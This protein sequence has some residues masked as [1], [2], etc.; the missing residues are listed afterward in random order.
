MWIIG[1]YAT[2]CVC[3]L[4][5]YTVLCLIGDWGSIKHLYICRNIHLVHVLSF[6]HKDRGWKSSGEVHKLY[7]QPHLTF[8]YSWI[9][10]YN[11]VVGLTG[12]VCHVIS[13]L[14][15]LCFMISHCSVG[16]ERE[17]K[18]S[19]CVEV[20]KWMDGLVYTYP[21]ADIAVECLVP[22]PCWSKYI[23][24]CNALWAYV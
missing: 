10:F 7:F 13:Y 14:L 15:S 19:V 8:V 5:P 9:M 24:S 18:V 3:T 4:F 2:V 23:P 6:S 12:A 11:A 20:K 1:C 22:W 21:W 17:V 16:W